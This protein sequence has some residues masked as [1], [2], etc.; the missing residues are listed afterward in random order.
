MENRPILENIR[1]AHQRICPYIHKTPVLSCNALNEIVGANLFFKCENFQKVGAFKFRGACNT[2]FSLSSE[3][4][5]SRGVVTHSSGNHAAA[6]ALAAKKRGITARIIMPSNAPKV[7]IDAVKNYGGIITFCEPTLASRES[8]A[9]KVIEQTGA[10]MIHPYNDYRIIAGQGTAALELIEE[11]IDLDYIFAPVGGGGLLS[12]TAITAKALNPK[13]KV[14]GCEPKN[15]DDAYRSIKAGRII[16][17]ENPNTIADGL[18]TAL[19]DKT[20]P[21]IQELVDEIVLV[22]EQQIITAMRYI[23]ERM[24]IIVEPS[25]AVAFAVLLSKKLNVTDKNVGIIISGGNVDFSKFF[26]GIR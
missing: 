8:T 15:A 26:E 22:T 9:A 5:A 14:I 1:A 12:G 18:K 7:K 2:V 10:T 21:I 19:G 6:L 23:F 24:K 3:E 4:E 16:P 17:P 11:I 13:I 25:S 20:F